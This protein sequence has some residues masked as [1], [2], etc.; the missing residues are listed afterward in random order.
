MIGTVDDLAPY[1]YEADCVVIPIFYGDG[2]KVKTAE[3]MMY[4]KR[5]LATKEALEGY[6]YQGVK[7]INRCETA[8]E[9]IEEISK[10]KK[11]S[12]TVCTE[13][14]KNYLEYYDTSKMTQKFELYLKE[15]LNE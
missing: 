8:I 6:V 13:V 3:A 9:F 11:E 14:R 1:Y 7:G 12:I 10:L 4:G 2:M 5:I 15:I